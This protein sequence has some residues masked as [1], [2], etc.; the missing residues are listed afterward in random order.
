[1]QRDQPLHGQRRPGHRPV[2]TKAEHPRQRVALLTGK[3]VEPRPLASD[4]PAGV[5]I[6]F[7]PDDLTPP[8]GDRLLKMRLDDCFGGRRRGPRLCARK[9]QRGLGGSG[10][11]AKSQRHQ[12][13]TQMKKRSSRN[14]SCHEVI[15]A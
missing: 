11:R 8:K 9:I 1:L 10:E 6:V 5:A 14:G 4:Q 7:G 15:P 2:A 3:S 13:S 12:G